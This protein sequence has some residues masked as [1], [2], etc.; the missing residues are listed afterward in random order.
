MVNISRMQQNL[1]II[2]LSMGWVVSCA[3]AIPYIIV[4]NNE[5]SM[6]IFSCDDSFVV[7]INIFIVPLCVL[8]MVATAIAHYFVLKRITESSTRIRKSKVTYTK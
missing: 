5:S 1:L 4:R 2:A 8:M 3:I 7:M 6:C